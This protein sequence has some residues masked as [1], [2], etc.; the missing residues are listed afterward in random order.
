MIPALDLFPRTAIDATQTID[1]GTEYGYV[2]SISLGV[3]F[4]TLFSITGLLHLG[5]VIYARRYWWML[6]MV[7]GGLLEVLGWAGRLWSHFAPA[8]FSPYVMQICCLVIAPTFYSA[9]LYWAAGLA[10]AHVAPNKSWFTAKWFKTFFIT[11]DVVS[12]VVQAV[13]GGM[14]GSAVGTNPQQVKTGSNIM[15]AGIVIQLVVMLFYVTYMAVWAFRA[16]KQVDLAGRRFQW[17]LLAMLAASIG[18]IVR[19]CYRTPE[20]AEGFDGWIAT[21]QI[22]MLFDAVPIA[23]ASFVLNI[24]HPHWFLVY[25]P[26]IEAQV[27][28][29]KPQSSGEDERAS[30]EQQ[31]QPAVRRGD[32]QETAVGL[33]GGEKAGRDLSVATPSYENAQHV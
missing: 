30:I 31:L 21:Q 18:I 2:P 7:A 32:S 11:A 3:I 13:G 22:W 25:S 19:G 8:N 10:I 14:A 5:Q 15:L 26:E 4:I 28:S 1:N 17:M 29:E 33:P 9:V 20:L 12:L 23:F 24:I 6:C 27:A 16:R